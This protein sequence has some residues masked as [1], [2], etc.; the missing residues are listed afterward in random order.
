MNVYKLTYRYI[1]LIIIINYNLHKY[2]IA[3]VIYCCFYLF[4]I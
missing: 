2:F 4:I 1:L 3:I